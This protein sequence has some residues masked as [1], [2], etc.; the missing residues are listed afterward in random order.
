MR[1]HGYVYFLY[2]NH[3]L[4]YI[5]CSTNI[6][7]RLEHHPIIKSLRPFGVVT[8]HY[9]KFEEHLTALEFEEKAIIR[10][11]PPFNF[12]KVSYQHPYNTL[13][14]LLY[15]VGSMKAIEIIAQ[16]L[17]GNGFNNIIRLVKMRNYKKS[18]LESNQA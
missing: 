1:E 4:A 6:R 3:E 13:L 11:K 15:H 16:K 9:I 8:F 2:F 10:F 18:Q 7:Q 5:G 12:Q 17:N 14:F